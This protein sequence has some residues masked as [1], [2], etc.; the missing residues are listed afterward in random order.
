MGCGFLHVASLAT[1]SADSDFVG[2]RMRLACDATCGLVNA[3][4]ACLGLVYGCER[5]LAILLCFP[6]TDH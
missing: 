5:S 4:D 1:S 3:Q 6:A 2:G